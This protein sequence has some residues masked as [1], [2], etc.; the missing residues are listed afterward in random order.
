[1]EP[2]TLTLAKGLNTLRFWRCDPPQK[3]IAIKSFTLKPAR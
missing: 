2:V 1:M 3:G